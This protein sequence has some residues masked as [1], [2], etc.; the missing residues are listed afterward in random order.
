MR[1]SFRKLKEK[2][3]IKQQVSNM[4][5]LT[6]LFILLFF[7]NLLSCKENSPKQE[8]I[9]KLTTLYSIDFKQEQLNCTGEK[10][11]SNKCIDKN[12]NLSISFDK[13]SILF[14]NNNKN[15][16][17]KLNNSSDLGY[18]TFLFGSSNDEKIILIDNFLENG[19]LFLVYYV[20]N[21]NIKFLGKNEVINNTE[22][23]NAYN[24]KIKKT[25]DK[26][27]IF[28]NPQLGNFS[29]DI[30]KAANLNNNDDKKAILN[31]NF[32]NDNIAT[33]DKIT[34]ELIFTKDKS[35]KLIIN[36]D[37]LDYIQKNTASSN[38]S[39][40]M[41]LSKY[42]TQLIINFYDDESTEWREEDLFRIIGYAANTTDPLF[43]KYWKN[44]PE[45]WNNGQGGY[46]LGFCNVAYHDQI[47]AKLTNNFKQN[48]YYNLPYLEEMVWYGSDFDKAGAP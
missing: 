42:V 35:G 34:S 17:D 44:N 29:L 40:S 11:S 45:E 20:N 26:V 3:K 41:S 5:N 39:Y 14:T 9:D 16:I 32:L 37:I 13:N 10:Y 25:D 33:P 27:D 30:E 36:T 6:N 12:K 15:Y 21:N 28:L 7:F 43:K 22:E 48:K 19:H 24:F 4:K 2:N 23:N 47:W 18:E 31:I 38:N 46:I 1:L 8:K